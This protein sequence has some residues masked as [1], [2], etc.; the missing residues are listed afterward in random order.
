LSKGLRIPS[1]HFDS[2]ENAMVAGGAE[3][4]RLRR[5]GAPS[6]KMT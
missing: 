2:N 4:F 3:I 1:D 6:L 5:E